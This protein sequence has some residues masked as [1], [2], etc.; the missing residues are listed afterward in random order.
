M[1]TSTNKR[2][3]RTTPV[4]ALFVWLL[5]LL[6]GLR[7]TIPHSFAQHFLAAIFSTITTKLWRRKRVQITS[8]PLL[9]LPQDVVLQVMGFL[10]RSNVATR[11]T[12]FCETHL[13]ETTKRLLLHR[14][15]LSNVCKAWHAQLQTED[16]SDDS[17][18]RTL[19][20]RPKPVGKEAAR[21]KGSNAS[22]SPSSMTSVWNDSDDDSDD[23]DAEEESDQMDISVTWLLT[24]LP[25]LVHAAMRP[26]DQICDALQIIL[27]RASR[28]RNL[29]AQPDDE[30]EATGDSKEVTAH[31]NQICLFMWDCLTSPSLRRDGAHAAKVVGM[32]KALMKSKLPAA[33]ETMMFTLVRL[34]AYLLI[35]LQ[36]T[37][38]D[39][40]AFN[41]PPSSI[42]WEAETHDPNLHIW[43]TNPHTPRKLYAGLLELA[44]EELD[45]AMVANCTLQTNPSDSDCPTQQ[46]EASLLVFGALAISCGEL[47]AGRWEMIL[48]EWIAP[49]LQ[50]RDE[51]TRCMAFWTVGRVVEGMFETGALDENVRRQVFKQVLPWFEKGLGDRSSKVVMAASNALGKSFEALD[52]PLSLQFKGPLLAMVLRAMRRKPRL[53]GPFAVLNKVVEMVGWALW[54]RS[55][56][57]DLQEVMQTVVGAWGASAGDSWGYTQKYP[58]E[59]IVAL[60]REVVLTVGEKEKRTVRIRTAVVEDGVGAVR[61]T[62]SKGKRV[63]NRTRPDKKQ[64]GAGEESSNNSSTSTST[65][66]S[67]NN[68]SISSMSSIMSS[69]S[70][71]SSTTTTTTISVNKHQATILES[72]WIPRILNLTRQALEANLRL[73]TPLRTELVAACL[74]LLCTFLELIGDDAKALFQIHAPWLVD[75]CLLPLLLLSQTFFRP[76]CVSTPLHALIGEAIS[77]DPSRFVSC[78]PD[79]VPGLV[80][81]ITT[82]QL[83]PWMHLQ[84]SGMGGESS[85]SDPLPPASS[86]SSSSSSCSLDVPGWSPGGPHPRSII[87]NAVY[88]FGQLALVTYTPPSLPSSPCSSSSSSSSSSL[89]PY[90]PPVIQALGRILKMKPLPKSNRGE[91]EE[92]DEEE[93]VDEDDPMA[94]LELLS[95]GRRDEEVYLRVTCACTLGAVALH[96]PAL[97]HEWLL[98]SR[99]RQEARRARRREGGG[100]GQRR[101]RQ[102]DEEEGGE[103]DLASRWCSLLVEGPEVLRGNLNRAELG[104]GLAG[105]TMV[106]AHDVEEGGL[107]LLSPSSSVP[108]SSPTGAG[109][110]GGSGLFTLWAKALAALEIDGPAFSSLPPTLTKETAQRVFTTLQ[111]Q[112]PVA[113]PSLFGCVEEADEKRLRAVGII[114]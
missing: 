73:S 77:L 27:N 104:Y 102:Q 109:D 25:S 98:A 95:G 11:S 67:T 54:E 40:R 19:F 3:S 113:Y 24:A 97:V 86:S 107:A 72:P 96:S 75:E 10:A 17:W 112:H 26:K 29:P 63:A 89:P 91:D 68:G 4:A 34:L 88:A 85:A 8:F 94:M 83:T 20:I 101:R 87:N 60:W 52:F 108:S 62:S 53:P 110:G 6:E 28:R 23:E 7:R 45:P 22:S 79:W 103:E 100:Q 90:L 18:V 30:N 74:N 99:E 31:I 21:R 13:K 39:R 82:T 93:D 48:G 76:G 84:S 46:R 69:S 106:L 64:G 35:H 42:E 32:W 16:A 114:C 33:R 65:S 70:S 56:G 9:D 105:L 12:E 61:L 59:T 14:A 5:W 41:R 50:D 15:L 38:E 55:E 51:M 1:A 111:S 81:T 78:M 49:C 43:G 57:K 36:A 47:L 92:E 71:S 80:R 58:V 44:A 66:T 2:A 37:E